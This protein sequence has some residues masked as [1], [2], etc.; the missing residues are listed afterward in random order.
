MCQRVKRHLQKRLVELRDYAA[1]L[2]R[3]I[4][5]ADH[6]DRAQWEY[7]YELTMARLAENE[8]VLSVMNAPPARVIET[9]TPPVIVRHDE[10]HVSD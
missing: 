4:A 5:M 6:R 7:Q 2:S 10:N 3:M 9:E 1:H 8:A